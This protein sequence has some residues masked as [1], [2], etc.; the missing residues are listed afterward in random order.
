MSISLNCSLKLSLFSSLKEFVDTLLTSVREGTKYIL[1]SSVKNIIIDTIDLEAFNI[2]MVMNITF[3]EE[4]TKEFKLNN[5]L[6]KQSI[7]LFNKLF[8][9]ITASNETLVLNEQGNT[10]YLVECN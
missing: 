5:K 9:P 7:I 3:T 6:N 1:Q 8:G 10:T 4:K 2:P